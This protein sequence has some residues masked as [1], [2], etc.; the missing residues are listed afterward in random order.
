MLPRRLPS[1]ANGGSIMGKKLRI[2]YMKHDKI[3]KQIA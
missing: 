1:V 2:Y 3:I